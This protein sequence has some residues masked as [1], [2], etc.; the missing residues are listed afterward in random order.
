MIKCKKLGKLFKNIKRVNLGNVS[1]V[2]SD[3]I[4]N[5]MIQYNTP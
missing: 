5:M 2:I 3:F 4:L 1:C